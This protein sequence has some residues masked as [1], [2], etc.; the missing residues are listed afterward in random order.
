MLPNNKCK[1]KFL[2][3]GTLSIVERSNFAKGEIGD[4][5]A[6]TWLGIACLGNIPK[7]HTLYPRWWAMLNRCYNQN[8]EKYK[9]YGAE[10]ITVCDRWL[11]L[12]YY[13]E[14]IIELNGGTLDNI[15]NLEIDKDIKVLGNKVYSKETCSV[16]SKQ[17]NRMEKIMRNV[18]PFK[19]INIETKEESVCNI[20][21]NEY[22][23]QNNLQP[24]RVSMCLNKKALTH[25]GF[26]FE[27]IV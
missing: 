13:V 19:V 22:C 27:Y 6:K 4:K 23:R 2:N 21:L 25:R 20:P 9:T 15:E 8:V 24:A 17:E 3:T 26:T 18:K 14:D 16:V 11:C 10:G 5:Y 12:E 7:N 1:I